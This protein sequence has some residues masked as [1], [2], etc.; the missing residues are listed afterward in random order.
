MKKISTELEKVV[1]DEPTFADAVDTLIND[2]TRQSTNAIKILRERFKDEITDDV[3]SLERF[4]DV[5]KFED[6]IN[7]ARN[8]Y[9]SAIKYIPDTEKA[10]INGIYDNLYDTCIGAV[11]DLQRLFS[12]PYRLDYDGKKLVANRDEVSEAI[13]DNFKV[14][15]SEDERKYYGLVAN[16]VNALNAMHDFEVKHGFVKFSYSGINS[17]SRL[18]YFRKVLPMSFYQKFDEQ[19]FIDALKNG[20]MGVEKDD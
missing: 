19:H 3:K 10:R 15:L 14:E 12:L 6:F 13:R 2:I 17:L 16:V 8:S 7:D 18:G 20:T 5:A 11:K 4:S 9:L 1:Y